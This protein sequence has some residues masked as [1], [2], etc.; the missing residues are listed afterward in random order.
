M[1]FILTVAAVVFFFA[2]RSLQT[3]VEKLEA[4]VKALRGVSIVS[5]VSILAPALLSIPN[6]PRAVGADISEVTLPARQR[7]GLTLESASAP[8][9]K[10]GPRCSAMAGRTS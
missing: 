5:T 3:K 1:T 4:E 10:P 2:F 6:P 7:L 9:P 8:L